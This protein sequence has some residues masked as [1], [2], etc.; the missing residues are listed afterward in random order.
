MTEDATDRFVVSGLVLKPDRSSGVSE[1]VHGDEQA[2]GLLDPFGDLIARGPGVLA[3]AG[4]TG[5]SQSGL[6]R[7]ATRPERV[8]IFVD[9]TRSVLGRTETQLT[10]FFTS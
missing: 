9:E 4:L 6:I 3:A 10:R 8:D 1:L 2:S 5:N 7:A